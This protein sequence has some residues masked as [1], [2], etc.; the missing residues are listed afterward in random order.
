M[1]PNNP[2]PNDP[3]Y[4]PGEVP[5][6]FAEVS[7]VANT[8]DDVYEFKED[9]EADQDLAL[10]DSFDAPSRADPSDIYD[11][12]ETDDVEAPSFGD[13]GNED[14]YEFKDD[15]AP[16]VTFQDD[17]VAEA[18][19]DIYDSQD[20]SNKVELNFKEQEVT[21]DP[22]EFKEG[23]PR[24]RQA[25]SSLERPQTP[26][27]RYQ[28][29][30]NN[31]PSPRMPD[32][33]AYKL[34]TRNTGP[35]SGRIPQITNPAPQGGHK[36]QKQ[37]R[38]MPRPTGLHSLGAPAN[39]PPGSANQP[40][41]SANQPPGSANQPP[42][43]AT[44]HHS[45]QTQDGSPT[46][47]PKRAPAAPHGGPVGRPRVKSG[48]YTRRL[49]PS[50][51]NRRRMPLKKGPSNMGSPISGQHPRSPQPA[52]RPGTRRHAALPPKPG[53]GQA[54]SRSNI[55]A[56]RPG[57]RTPLGSG[58]RPQAPSG[59]RPRPQAPSQGR[60]QAPPQGRPQAPPQ[61]R[62]LRGP[63]ARQTYRLPRSPTGTE[64]KG[65]PGNQSYEPKPMERPSRTQ[66][67]EDPPFPI[68]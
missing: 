51:Q 13:V 38:R 62:Q 47:P 41:G 3:K 67:D 15:S 52:P 2:N 32:S 7:H 1:T 65:D 40:P 43:S 22:Y 4:P 61:G 63:Q 55:P 45:L 31:S 26:S 49:P 23:T 19:P 16:E 28:L 5:E 21:K 17:F 9:D 50:E 33:G 37:S 48:C 39:Q 64:A 6:G 54:G 12:K 14:L 29:P 58:Q 36:R 30:R 56:P 24:S 11:Y 68:P 10:T 35:R 8:E 66:D 42:G 59:S 27:G 57:H 60:P 53:P 18:A 25:E 44:D 20:V 34:P 46:G